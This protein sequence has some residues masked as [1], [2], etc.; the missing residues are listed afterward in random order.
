MA[1]LTLSEIRTRSTGHFFDRDTMRFFRSS[2]W[3]TST[4][5]TKYGTRYDK[6]TDTNYVVVTDPWGKKHYHKFDP[7]SGELD[8]VRDEDVPVRMKTRDLL[9]KTGGI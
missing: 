3:S 8:S 4:Q 5:R 2:N 6:D 7:V 1:R 9:Q